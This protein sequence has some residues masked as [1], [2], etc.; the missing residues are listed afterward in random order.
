MLHIYSSF[1]RLRSSAAR[2][3]EKFAKTKLQFEWFSSKT[4]TDVCM[5]DLLCRSKVATDQIVVVALRFIIW[6][7]QHMVDLI[8]LV[9][10]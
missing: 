3:H 8:Y 5:L 10:L 1:H 9:T 6:F 4:E 2:S 7:Y